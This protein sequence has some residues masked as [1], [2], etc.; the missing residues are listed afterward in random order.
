M[1]LLIFILLLIIIY[2]YA[3]KPN[4]RQFDFK[5][6]EKTFICHRGLFNNIDIPENS[7]IAFQKAVDNNYGIEL[8]VQITTDNKLVVFHDTSLFRM[9]NID[10]DLVDCDYQELQS[11]HLLDT[12]HQIP[13][14]ADVLKVL[15][16]DTPLI[17]EIKADGRFIETTKLV[18]EMMKN[19]DG[20]YNIESFHPKVVKYLKQN[21]PD[22]I[23]G[24]LSYD[25]I[26][27]KDS[28]IP[29]ISKFILT[30]LLTNFINKP[31]YIAYDCNSY[32][33]L[34]FKIISKLYKGK[35]VAWTV[36][37]NDEFK[38]IK[39]YYQCFIFDSYI[40]DNNDL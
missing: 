24:Q 34:S 4:N 1:K 13:L 20:L 31:D 37:S 2:L 35:C 11:Y 17:I 22:I 6:Y 15:K 29:F 38:K 36:K 39:D 14:F 10:K 40:P 9:C 18:V 28:H 8:D 7:L 19:Y 26:K 3:I 30:Y 23:R 21:E 32:N 33:N 12:N 5:A 16:K 25:Y 27:D